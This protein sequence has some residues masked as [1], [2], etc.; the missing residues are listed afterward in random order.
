MRRL[1]LRLAPDA[2]TIGPGQ[3]GWTNGITDY[4]DDFNTH[5]NSLQVTLT[6]QFTRGLSFNANYA[7]QHAISWA[8]DFSHLEPPAVKGNDGFVRR[9]QFILYGLYELPFGRNKVF[10]TNVE[11]CRRTRSSEDGN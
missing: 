3:C 1:Q 10:G 8:G 7:W 2:L 11:Q 5:Y 9:Q 4:G 6:K